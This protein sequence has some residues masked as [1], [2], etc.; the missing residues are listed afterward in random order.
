MFAVRIARDG[1][2]FTF[3]VSPHAGNGVEAT[4]IDS[5]PVVIAFVNAEDPGEAAERAWR[6]GDREARALDALGGM[7]ALL[8]QGRSVDQET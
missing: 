3:E 6:N 8:A 7:K 2:T 5:T 4:A 1:E